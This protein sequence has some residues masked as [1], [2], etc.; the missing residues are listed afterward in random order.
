MSASSLLVRGE[1]EPGLGQALLLVTLF[2]IPLAHEGSLRSLRV[3]GTISNP[4]GSQEITLP[5]GWRTPRENGHY[6]LTCYFF[7]KGEQGP[8]AGAG[9]AGGH[10][11][12]VRAGAVFP[13]VWGWR[14]ADCPL[15]SPKVAT[16][17]QMA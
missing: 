11:K 3:L 8:T 1:M 9:Q 10:P 15:C 12:V 17:R 5:R 4:W 13:K 2:S 14:R 7:L 6:S 16:N